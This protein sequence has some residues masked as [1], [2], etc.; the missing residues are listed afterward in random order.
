MIRIRSIARKMTRCCDISDMVLGVLEVMSN[1]DPSM[2][3]HVLE[4]PPGKFRANPVSFD[5]FEV[6]APSCGFGDQD[7]LDSQQ[8]EFRVNEFRREF[9]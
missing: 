3:G 9:V 2:D 5:I 8:I 1:F 7:K 4:S 6:C